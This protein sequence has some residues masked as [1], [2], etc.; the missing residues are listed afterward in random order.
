MEYIKTYEGFF[1]K[2]S[3]DDK[4]A[5]GLINRLKKVKGESPYRIEKKDTIDNDAG[6]I[7]K[8]VTHFD[9][10]SIITGR[11]TFY[12]D[13]PSEVADEWNLNWRQRNFP[14]NNP[15]YSTK[16]ECTGEWEELKCKLK[17]Q[18]ELFDLV[19]KVYEQDIES[20]RINRIS[21]EYNPGADLLG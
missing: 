14:K 6:S 11:V 10:L 9:D 7:L 4:I 18:E 16:V 13:V 21:S 5:K 17:Y 3:E 15:F 1:T 2:E 8:Y 19:K 20:R 12:R